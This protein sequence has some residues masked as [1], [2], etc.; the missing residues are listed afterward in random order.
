MIAE[1]NKIMYSM[2][3][4]VVVQLYG[5]FNMPRDVND[6]HQDY[7]QSLALLKSDALVQ[8]WYQILMLHI[9]GNLVEL[10]SCYQS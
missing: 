8:C 9:L 1:W 4:R 3:V 10:S 7:V 2:T 6:E 5:L